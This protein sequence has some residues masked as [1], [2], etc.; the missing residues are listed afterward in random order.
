MIWPLSPHRRVFSQS[1][2]CASSAS[3]LR[4]FAS[5]PGGSLR[6]TEGRSLKP[7]VRQL[8]SA[9]STLRL[10]AGRPFPARKGFSSKLQ[11]RQLRSAS[12]TLRLAA[13]RPP[14]R[15][16]PSLPLRSAAWKGIFSKPQVRQLRFASSTLRLA[17]G[18][19]FP[20][21][22]GISSK[23]QVRQLRSA[24]S[25][26]RLAVGRPPYRNPPSL[27]LRSAVRPA[28]ERGGISALAAFIAISPQ[29]IWQ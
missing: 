19:P 26:L 8:R 9:S 25:T 4:R 17:A 12:S 10:A 1:R 2:K 29:R 16:P 22:K 3:R 18:R 5:L 20:A 27:P 21:R 7:Q 15:N 13:G 28:R 24:S 6:R 11:V 14:Y 23:P